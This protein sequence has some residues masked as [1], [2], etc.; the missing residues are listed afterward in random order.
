MLKAHLRRTIILGILGVI[1][2]GIMAALSPSIYEGRLEMVLGDQTRQG[3]TS[4]SVYTQDVANILNSVALTSLTTERQLLSSQAVFYQALS[5]VAQQTNRTALLDKWVDLYRM[6]DIETARNTNQQIDAGVALL[7]VRAYDPE[8]AASLAN[9][10]AK[11]YND[12]RQRNSRESVQTAL[13]YLSS[14]L[15]A[16][17]KELRAK[18]AA[19]QTF[20]KSKGFADLAKLASDETNTQ[21]QLNV[22]VQTLTSQLAGAEARVAAFQA[23]FDSMPKTEQNASISAKPTSVQNLEGNIGNLRAERSRLLEVYLE[24]A[25]K[26]K[27]LDTTIKTLEGELKKEMAKVSTQSTSSGPNGA[28]IQIGQLLAQTK[29]ERDGIRADLNATQGILSQQKSAVGLLP[30]TE[31]Q[32]L[33]LVRDLQLADERYKRLKA[34]SDDL[35]NRSETTTRAAQV[36]NVASPDPNP[37]APDQKKF[38]LIGAVAGLALG[39]LFSFA[40]E[41]LRLRIQSS[42]QLTALTGLPVIASIPVGQRTGAKG[43][44]AIATSGA[45]PPEAFRYMAFSMVTNNTKTLRTFLFTGVKSSMVTYSSATQF[46]TAVAKG[47]TRVLLVDADLLKSPI[48]TVLNGGGKEGLSNL[49]GS[50]ESK[51]VEDLVVSTVHENLMLLPAGTDSSLRYLTNAPQPKLEAIMQSLRLYCDVVIIAVPP[52]DVLADAACI[53]RLVDDVVLVVSGAQTNYRSVPIAQDLLNKAGAKAISI[54]MTEA[55]ADEEP[56]SAKS[57]YIRRG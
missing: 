39:L 19:L 9:A 57:A 38:I 31:A 20:K 47:G 18:E 33:Q 3:Q 42:T 32:Y 43:L 10:I 48:T 1:V 29:A 8:V 23:Q 4:N 28:R 53:A 44:R 49:L 22:R 16:T 46:A 11:K 7:K 37:I 36:L 14:N 27:A 41:A 5:D 56:F 50:E 35:K 21:T 34:Q 13:S 26:I 25:P 54:V 40:V 15:D 6:Y 30:D 17:D 52:C 24:D 12:I 51:K 2:G 55:Q 45:N